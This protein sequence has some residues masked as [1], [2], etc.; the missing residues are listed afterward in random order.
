[1]RCVNEY[2][3]FIEG[4]GFVDKNFYK[5]VVNSKGQSV[6][7]LLYKVAKDKARYNGFALHVNYNALGQVVEVSHIPFEFCRLPDPMRP[8]LQGKIAVS[9]D[10]VKQ[11]QRSSKKQEILWYDSFEPSL[12]VQQM[13][14]QTVELYKGQVLWYSVEGDKYPLAPIDPVIEDVES[15]ARIKNHK[16]KAI[17]TGFNADFALVT[18]QKFESDQERD[19]YVASL[20]AFQGD[21]AAGNIM[22][23]EVDRPEQ[24]PDILSFP[25]ADQDK[26]FEYTETSIHDNIRKCF[27]IPPV[28]IGEATAGKLGTS[29]EIIDACSFYNA[30]TDP[31]RRAVTEIF[32]RVFSLWHNK[33]INLTGDYSIQPLVMF[34]QGNLPLAVQIGVG[35]TQAL[36]SILVDPVLNSSQKV[37]MLQILFDIPLDNATAMVLGADN[38]GA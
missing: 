23:V 1:M 19:E 20:E 3:K 12:A 9:S 18:Q 37:N 15:D 17:A 4:T 22:L 38:T 6:D 5:A 11:S 30:I 27:G 24:K 13:L 7:R 21:E 25:R 36:V 14:E 32:Q 29:Q 10:W 2:A 28:L 16:R 33:Y 35:G 26:R 31:E 34:S 8:D